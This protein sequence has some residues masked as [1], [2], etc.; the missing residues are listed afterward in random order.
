[1]SS[2]FLVCGGD[3]PA[4]TAVH[5]QRVGPRLRRLLDCQYSGPFGEILGINC[6][7]AWPMRTQQQLLPRE[8]S[9]QFQS[10][11]QLSVCI[12]LGLC[13]FVLNAEGYLTS[14]CESRDQARCGSDVVI[15]RAWEQPSVLSI[16][17][18]T[19]QLQT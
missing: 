14:R 9:S 16:V 10:Q 17:T 11:N 18:C 3:V 8:A 4:Q 13:F 19:V 2:G 5:Y 1:M 12:Q 15:R 7:F 6:A